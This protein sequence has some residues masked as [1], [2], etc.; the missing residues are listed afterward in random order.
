MYITTTFKTRVCFCLVTYFVGGLW[1]GTGNGRDLKEKKKK[2]QSLSYFTSSLIPMIRVLEPPGYRH[3]ENCRQTILKYAI[4]HPLTTS[5]S[6][7]A[8]D[9]S[10]TTMIIRF[11]TI[12]YTLPLRPVIHP[13]QKKI[14]N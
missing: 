6:H 11:N 8:S 5:N 4:Q 1:E 13:H 2:K 7:L 10:V 12:E 9:L 3:H 14:N